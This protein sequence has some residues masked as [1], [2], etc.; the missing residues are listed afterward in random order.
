MGLNNNAVSCILCSCHWFSSV[1]S[2]PLTDWVVVRTRGNDSAEILFQ[3]FLQEA[4]VSSPGMG[5]DVHSL[6]LFVEH[7]LCRPRRLPPTKV[8]WKTGLETLSWRVTCP[9][10]ASF[11]FLSVG[12]QA[13]SSLQNSLSY[14]V[15]C[16][17]WDK[18]FTIIVVVT[19]RLVSDCVERRCTLSCKS[20]L[21]SLRSHKLSSW[22]SR[23]ADPPPHTHTH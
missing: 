13:S 14:G 4:L 1:Q 16:S 18:A 8:P 3:S 20:H 12:Q 7:F 22:R 2:S 21:L 11:R 23:C 17:S 19:L 10:L 5:R 9:N 6:T 15:Q